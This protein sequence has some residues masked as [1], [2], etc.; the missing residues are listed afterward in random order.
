VNSRPGPASSIL[1]CLTCGSAEPS[2]V[3]IFPSRCTATGAGWRRGSFSEAIPPFRATIR[4]PLWLRSEAP[5]S[6]YLG[7]EGASIQSQALPQRRFAPASG[8]EVSERACA[9]AGA[10]SSGPVSGRGKPPEPG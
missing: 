4:L 5:L 10:K 2:A 7:L 1:T 8:T 9:P 3:P 6:R